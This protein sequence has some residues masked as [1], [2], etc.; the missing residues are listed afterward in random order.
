MSFPTV[1]WPV[2]R[3]EAAVDYAATEALDL[4][5]FGHM[6]PSIGSERRPEDSQELVSWKAASAQPQL[7]THSILTETGPP[8]VLRPSTRT[9]KFLE[10][11]NPDGGVQRMCSAFGLTHRDIDIPDSILRDALTEAMD[12]SDW[13]HIASMKGN[14]VASCRP[15]LNRVDVVQCANEQGVP[16]LEWLQKACNKRDVRPVT[17]PSNERE[18]R[19]SSHRMWALYPGGDCNSELWALPLPTTDDRHGEFPSLRY[20]ARANDLSRRVEVKPSI[21]FA[22]T[23][24]QVITREAHPGFAC[25]RTD[26]MVSLLSLAQRHLP[27]DWVPEV[28]VSVA[29]L[30]YLYDRGDKWTCHAS[31]SPWTMSELALASGTGSV[32]LWDSDAGR[33]TELK[34]SDI[35]DRCD[36]QWNCCEYWNSPRSLLCAN[37]DT[38]YMLDSRSGTSRTDIM[39]LVDSPFAATD[40][41]FTAIC[42]SPLHP[43]QAIAASTH[44][45]RVYD[46][47]N[48]S[49]PVVA[50]RHNLSTYDPPIYLQACAIPQYEDGVAAVVLAASEKSSRV[51]SYVYGQHA[52]DHPY[53]SIEQTMLKSSTKSAS[54]GEAIQDM[55]AIDMKETPDMTMGYTYISSHL[56]SRLSG[57]SLQLLPPSKSGANADADELKAAPKSTDAVCITVDEAGALVGRRLLLIPRARRQIG[58]KAGK[59]RSA[60]NPAFKAPLW[61]GARVSLGAVVDGMGLVLFDKVSNDQRKE[62]FWTEL[63]KRGVAYTRKDMRAAYRYLLGTEGAAPVGRAANGLDASSSDLWSDYFASE[64]EKVAE[65]KSTASVT[66]FEFVNLAF[67][68]LTNAPNLTMKD[69]LPSWSACGEG[70][71][72]ALLSV[73][74]GEIDNEEVSDSVS[75][76]VVNSLRNLQIKDSRSS[77]QI[78][79]SSSTYRGLERIFGATQ[80]SSD[81]HTQAALAR[82]AKDLAL[83]NLRL[84]SGAESSEQPSRQAIACRGLPEL[85][86]QPKLEALAEQ[87]SVPAKQL[88][89][90]WTMG[91]QPKPKQSLPGSSQAGSS[92]LARSLKRRP[93]QSQAISQIAPLAHTQP[94][95]IMDAFAMASQSLTQARRSQPSS[96]RSQAKKK[97][98]KAGF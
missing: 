65:A 21:E 31:W 49:Q 4:G 69:E 75:S 30:P 25:V 29:G 33:A 28:E 17:A 70:V 53:V 59:L 86:I 46:Q 36:N 11:S 20:R 81:A 32:R 95:P 19:W 48:L 67:N 2:H 76:A 83:V 78:V 8:V 85:D 26:N 42:P 51:A 54:V 22:R 77:P 52:S 97:I 79:D 41:L 87:W 40:E 56:S 34:G 24:R 74:D 62:R 84:G 96:S 94:Q 72:D 1:T 57:L 39:S 91:S 50:W 60:F 16:G 68:A 43:M 92:Q 98:R 71:R 38:L 13:N 88:G 6:L 44:Y 10:F 12:E 73:P 63:R 15:V 89:N 18:Y 9:A 55:L 27:P 45:I 80:S 64:L 47:R 37:P 58:S 23:I 61:T 93:G 66:G 5:V 7:E 3:S 14:V 90:I 35:S 82:A